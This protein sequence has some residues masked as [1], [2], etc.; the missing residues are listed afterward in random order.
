MSKQHHGILTQEQIQFYE[1]NGYLHIKNIMD[2]WELE[3]LKN[4]SLIMINYCKQ[5]R[6]PN[7]E[8]L[9]RM[10]PVT[11]N[12]VLTR[13]NGMY[14]KSDAFFAL[15]GHPRLLGIAESIHGPNIVSFQDAMVVKMPEYGAP[16]PWH[17]DPGHPRVK[18]PLDVDVYLDAATP[19]NGCLYVVPGSHLWQGF[20]LQDM[21][22]EH[23]FM[24]PGA[25]P[26]ITEPGDVLL[27][28]PNLLHG[29]RTTRG[30]PIR[31]VHYFAFFTIEELLSRGGQWDADYVRS[32]IRVMLQA[33]ESRS[34][35]PETA[36][37]EPYAYNPTLPEFK[38]NPRELGYVEKYVQ[39]VPDPFESAYRYSPH[40][41]VKAKI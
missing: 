20:D 23:G 38:L 9:Y 25:I 15:F 30:K 1:E 10:D 27:H 24:L 21:L 2:S 22:D 11:G 19:E 36:G 5:T 26:V 41:L 7:N 39:R 13:V 35:L 33:I 32:W 34:Q 12:M 14:T 28:S 16:V 6:P 8:Y 4:E 18:P 40:N 37:E 29:S 31:R 17:R 3:R